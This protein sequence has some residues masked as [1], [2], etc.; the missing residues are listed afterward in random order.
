MR[1]KYL[2][3]LFL[4]MI[5]CGSLMAQ[6]IVTGTVRDKDGKPVDGASVQ[7]KGSKSGTS[8]TPDGKF[9]LGFPAGVQKATLVITSVGMTKHA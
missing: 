3:F 9:S 5:S 1:S 6:Q 4:L 7:F 8:T 2:L